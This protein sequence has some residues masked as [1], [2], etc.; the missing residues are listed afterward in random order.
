LSLAYVETSNLLIFSGEE[1]GGRRTLDFGALAEHLAEKLDW[2][3]ALPDDDH[4]ARFCID[5]L[6]AHPDRL[7]EVIGEIAMGRSILER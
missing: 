7:D 4:V 6:D 3:Q 2:I 1:T 5:G